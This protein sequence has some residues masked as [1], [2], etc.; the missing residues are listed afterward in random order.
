MQDQ[1]DWTARVWLMM[2]AGF[3]TADRTVDD[4]FWHEWLNRVIG[5]EADNSVID[6][7][8]RYEQN[9]SWT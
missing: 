6:D 9:T 7:L 3:K 8:C 4:E 2:I 5:V 1:R